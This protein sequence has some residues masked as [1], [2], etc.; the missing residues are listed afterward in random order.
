VSALMEPG[1]VWSFGAEVR[2]VESVD[3]IGEDDQGKALAIEHDIPHGAWRRTV[4]ATVSVQ[5]VIDALLADPDTA[6]AL[7]VSMARWLIGAREGVTA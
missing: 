3:P 5:P 4:I 1:N 2:G 7:I 6:E